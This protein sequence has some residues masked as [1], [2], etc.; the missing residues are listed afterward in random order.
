M[1]ARTL[2]VVAAAA[3]AVVPPLPAPG[4]DVDEPNTGRFDGENY[5]ISFVDATDRPYPELIEAAQATHA[6][7]FEARS[8]KIPPVSRRAK[9]Q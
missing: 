3:V 5:N 2:A 1:N 8:G 4:A 9:A 6:R 7:L